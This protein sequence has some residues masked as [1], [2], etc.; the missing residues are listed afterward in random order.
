[1]YDTSLTTAE[2]KL[3]TH[4]IALPHLFQFRLC[5]SHQ[6]PK[7]V[8]KKIRVVDTGLL[9]IDEWVGNVASS[10]DSISVA[11]VEVSGPT[12]EPWLTLDYDEWLCVTSGVLELEYMDD[13][14]TQQLLRVE[15]GQTAL[16]EKGERFHPVFP[17]GNTSYIPICRPAFSPNRCKREEEG[18]SDVSVRL[19]DLHG[20]TEETI[21]TEATYSHEEEVLYH[22]CQKA[23]W[24]AAVQEGRA[25]FPP[26]F[27]KDGMFTHATAVP[28]RLI[29]TAN[30]FYTSSQG[31]WIC[32]QLSR[33]ALLKLGIDTVFEE[34][35]P[36][37]DTAT[38]SEWDG[39]WVCPHIF[40][41]IPTHLAGVVTKTFRMQRDENGTFLYIEGLTK[42]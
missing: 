4:I 10:D 26:T 6:M 19:K 27:V 24:D 30:H 14:G 7:I 36:V 2:A 11:T 29:T 40:G 42:N 16:V 17:V 31:D 20:S 15:A 32:L 1:M 39:M 41:G 33:S 5:R 18:T 25:Y 3:S 34:A 23:Q 35:K 12:S 8:G 28:S 22:M 37:G 9:A 21:T 13:Q 38:D